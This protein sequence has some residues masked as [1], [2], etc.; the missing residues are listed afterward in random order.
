MNNDYEDIESLLMD[1]GKDVYRTLD[2]GGVDKSIKRIYEEEVENMYNEFRPS[3]YQRRRESGGFGDRSN[4]EEDIK[5]GTNSVEYT[6]T[7]ITSAEST[8]GIG[9]IQLDEFIENGIYNWK[10]KPPARPIYARTQ[11]RIDSENI[12]ENSLEK[13]LENQGW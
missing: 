3:M 4:W 7:N 12:V 13:E 11:K 5:L 6:M 2:G 8:G 9:I 1:L 10:R